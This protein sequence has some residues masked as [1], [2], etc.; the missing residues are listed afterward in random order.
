TTYRRYGIT[1]EIAYDVRIYN[2]NENSTQAVK[3][4]QV[5]NLA[6]L[7]V[8]APAAPSGL[9]AVTASSTQ[10]N[11]SWTAPG[12][13]DVNT[14]GDQTTSPYLVRYKVSRSATSSVRYG[15]VIT[16]TTDAFTSL[17]S[18]SDAATSLS[19]TSINPGT[20]YNFTVAALNAINVAYGASSSA[21]TA[22]TSYPTAPSY[23]VAT[24]GTTLVNVGTLRGTYS[25][26]GGYSLDGVTTQTPVIN[27]SL[28]TNSN[29]I[30]GSATAI[31]NNFTEGSTSGTTGT[32]YAYGGP[33][34]TYQEAE[35][36]ASTTL[37]GFGSVKAN[38][39]FDS[40]SGITRLAFSS[41][42]DYYAAGATNLQ[43]FYK[44]FSMYTQGLA[45]STNF[46]A[47][48]SSYSLRMSHAPVGGTQVT[49]NVC[50]FYVDDAGAA[51]SLNNV[52]ITAGATTTYISG[53]PTFTSAS[54]FTVQMNQAEIA[55]FFLRNDK[56]HI[57][58]YISTS[59]GTSISSTLTI[60]HAA[61]GVSHKYRTAPSS[62][63]YTTS[64]TLHNTTG[65]TLAA[66]SSPEEIQFN[67]FTITLS[68]ATSIFDEAVVVKATPYSLYSNSGGTLVSGGFMNTSTGAT[69]A[70]RLDTKSV[71]ADRSNVA[72]A[73]TS[74]GQQVSSGTGSY[75]AIGSGEAGQA[76]DHSAT[77][78]GTS[79]LQLVNGRF[80]TVSVGNGYGD[81][82]SDYYFP[83]SLN[84]RDYTSITA[85][86]S[87]RV[88]TFKCSSVITSGTYER[89]AIAVT[90]SG[91]TVDLAQVGAANHTMQLKIQSATNAESW[92][93]GW[94]DCT[95]TVSGLGVGTGTDGTT[96]LNGGTSTAS[97]RHSFIVAGT[98]S[99]AIVYVRI[100]LRNNVNC[101]VS[102]I[103]V[104][105]VTSF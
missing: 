102:G 36:T 71:S 46:P 41:D 99:T 8:G 68:G 9:S 23:L 79:E 80:E 66:S 32:I 89:L 22:T 7:P 37:N 51:T 54:T 59:T 29:L 10:V 85:D 43:G 34:S 53:V 56:K 93:T 96:C 2:V 39:N 20:L 40:S 69:Q 35:N 17:T 70:I 45:V 78:V 48:Q 67:D 58:A 63:K 57:D 3:Y 49:T 91:L 74:G 81:Y 94:L 42:A 60:N 4:L 83:G 52:G 82:T 16:D 72:Y 24:T 87:Y 98:A 103:T 62:D 11:T 12:D 92:V 90:H 105:A 25:S 55:H 1:T 14:V 15:G 73:S 76:Y 65:L 86:S 64:S 5:L 26:S 84:L 47:S 44:T 50:T 31:R 97:L 28:M 21:A 33:T 38:A 95:N 13:R 101:Y 77:I 19:V 18:G 75:P 100:G 61:I 104:T 6:T 30:T 88:V 27:Y